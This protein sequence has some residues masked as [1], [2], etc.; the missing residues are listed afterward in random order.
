MVGAPRFELGTSCAQGRRATRLRYAPT[1]IALFILKHFPTLLLLRSLVF[2]SAVPKLYQ[3]LSLDQR[4]TRFQRHFV[5]EAVHLLQG[6]SF[7]LQFHLRILFEDFGIALSEELGNPLVG[8]TACA[9][10]SCIGRSQ[11]IDP[12]VW[13]SCAF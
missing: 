9:E 5:G 6:F 8:D 13:N 11:M 10:A 2:V 1:C 4:C 7:H 12:E 3:I